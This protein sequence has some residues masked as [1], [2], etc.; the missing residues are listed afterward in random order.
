MTAAHGVVLANVFA[1]LTMFGVIWV[2]QLVHYPLFAGVGADGFPAYEA[3][4]QAR[5]T[6]VVLPAMLLEL[7]TAVALLWLRPAAVPAWMAWTGLA[8]VGVV[9]VSTA[10]VQVPLHTA[11][12]AG[13][14][15]EAHARLVASNWMRTAAWSLRAALVLWMTAL[16]I[17]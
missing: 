7:G 15:G 4:H 12:A 8:L 11:L 6:L 17:R 1:T 9:W 5:I 3:A 2:V 16:L 13:F 14:D 10:V